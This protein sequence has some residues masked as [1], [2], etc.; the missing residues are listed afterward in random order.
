[1][2]SLAP[3]ENTLEIRAVPADG[4]RATVRR[5]VHYEAEASEPA[6]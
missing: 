2:V 5:V 1:M 4:Q 3:G 6:P